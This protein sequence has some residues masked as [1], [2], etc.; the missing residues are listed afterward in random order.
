MAKHE[1]LVINKMVGQDGQPLEFPVGGNAALIV[2]SAGTT[3]LIA[4]SSIE[5]VVQ[6]SVNIVT[7]FAN[8]DGA[9]PDFLIG[10]TGSTSKFAA[11]GVV[12]G[13]ALDQLQFS[14]VLSANTALLLTATAGTGTTET[15]AATFTAIACKNG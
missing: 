12:T 7:T 10:E 11:T 3:T 1:E 2:S 8:G 6:I 15:G 14:G 4:A 9:A 5:R 13:T